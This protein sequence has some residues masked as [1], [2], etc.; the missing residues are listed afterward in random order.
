MQAELVIEKQ[1]GLAKQKRERVCHTNYRLLYILQYK[2][3]LLAR[4]RQQA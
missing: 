1:E 4:Q 2:D 3:M